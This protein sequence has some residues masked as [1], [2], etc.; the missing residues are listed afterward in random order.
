MKSTSFG[1]LALAALAVVACNKGNNTAETTS[2]DTTAVPTTTTAEVTTT[3]TVPATDTVVTTT[4]TST[5]TIAK[6][7]ADTAKGAHKMEKKG[8]K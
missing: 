8:K 3:A 1:V 5:D 4:K 2:A 7:A 6:G